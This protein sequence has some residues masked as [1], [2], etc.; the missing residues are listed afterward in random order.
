MSR[1]N[2]AGV[3]TEVVVQEVAVKVDGDLEEGLLMVVVDT[4]LYNNIFLILI[5]VI[6]I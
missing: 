3:R 1:N 6:T 2:G 5:H 4:N